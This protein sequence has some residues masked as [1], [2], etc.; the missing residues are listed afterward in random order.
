MTQSADWSAT[1]T[2]IT[3]GHGGAQLAQQAEQAVQGFS[4]PT[5]PNWAFGD[6]AG[7]QCNLALVRLYGGTWTA[8]PPPYARC[9]TCPPRTAATASSCRRC[10]SVKL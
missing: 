1:P 3:I 4:D 8:Q 7:S 9:S 6:L 10:A 2:H 5:A